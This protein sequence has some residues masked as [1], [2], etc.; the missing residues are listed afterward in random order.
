MMDTC[1]EDY[2]GLDRYEARQLELAIK[3]FDEPVGVTQIR[4]AA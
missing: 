1:P 3:G 4:P 2:I